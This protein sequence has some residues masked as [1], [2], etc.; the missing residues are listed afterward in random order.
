MHAA[1]SGSEAEQDEADQD[2]HCSPGLP[3]LQP[4]AEQQDPAD[5]G[6]DR[7]RA[8][9]GGCHRDQAASPMITVRRAPISRA[10]AAAMSVETPQLKAE[11]KP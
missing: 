1:G 9:H 8:G 11:S 4:L 10:A 2:Q 6:D 7:V 5:Q 3:A